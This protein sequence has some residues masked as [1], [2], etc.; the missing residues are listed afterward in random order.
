MKRNQ[1]YAIEP[2][3][4]VLLS[5]MGL[6]GA[7]VLRRAGLPEDLLSRQEG[8]LKS[9]DYY[10]LWES[11]EAEM[12]DPLFP[13]RMGESLRAEAFSPPIFAAL[14]SP[15]YRVAAE[16]IRH[17]KPLIG[18]LS[19]DLEETPGSFRVSYIWPEE[20]GMPPAGLVAF[21][22]VFQVSLIRL[23]TREPVRPLAVIAPVPLEPAAEYG[24]YFGVPVE[25][26]PEHTV[27][28][29]RGDARLP[30]LTANE[31]LWETFEPDLRRRLADLDDKATVSERVSAVLLE[32]L[33]SGQTGIEQVA[34]RLIMSK[35]TLQRRLSGEGTSFAEV[36][37]TTRKDLSLH[38]LKRPELTSSQ[39]SFLLGF[40]DANSFF[41]AFHDWT[42]STP[43]TMR[44]SMAS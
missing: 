13:V 15:D 24:K 14:C 36:L 31:R 9:E 22:L 12:D 34:D 30:F 26:G 38:Y 32:S 1:G 17:Y 3:W 35:R 28:F 39:I 20:D 43:E 11:M 6:N 4:R 40:E 19:L 5:D 23:A 27:V 33:P 21:E 2:G 8:R 25:T 41:R 37:R 7:R 16:R 44:Q 10:R 18:P 42:G 29:S